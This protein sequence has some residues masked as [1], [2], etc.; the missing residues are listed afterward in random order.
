[1]RLD[2][3]SKRDTKKHQ[4][5]RY[6]ADKAISEVDFP[7]PVPSADTVWVRDEPSIPH[8]SRIPYPQNCELSICMVC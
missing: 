2:R 3:R 4:D 6:M 7:F 1:M 8:S 5:S